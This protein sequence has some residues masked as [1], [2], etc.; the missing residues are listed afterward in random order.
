MLAETPEGY[1]AVLDGDH[2]EVF[3]VE[4]LEVIDSRDG[5]TELL[6]TDKNIE[7]EE[8]QDDDDA[9]LVEYYE[10]H[11]DEDGGFGVY[12]SDGAWL[13]PDGSIVYDRD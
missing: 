9:S 6:R 1:L 2:C 12:L 13:Q 5:I 11:S 10:D 7:H 8:V 4:S 3:D